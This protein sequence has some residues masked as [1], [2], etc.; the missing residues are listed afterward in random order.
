[1]DSLLQQILIILLPIIGV[2][3]SPV[4]TKKIKEKK[5]TFKIL[6]CI[7]TAFMLITDFYLLTNQILFVCIIQIYLLALY[8]ILKNYITNHKAL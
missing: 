1:M 8:Q 6:T 2:I 5:I 3:I 7:V 4:R